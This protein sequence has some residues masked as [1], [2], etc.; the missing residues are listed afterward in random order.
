MIPIKLP[1][2][3]FT[4][5]EK[6]I[7]QFI[8]KQKRPQI[9]KAIL[10]KK[11]GAGGINLP[12]FRLYYKATVIK[13]VWYW[14]KTRTIDQWNKIESPERNPC[15]YEYLI[16][17]K[18]GKNIQKGKDG[19]FNKWCLENWTATCKRMKLEHFLIPYTKI[20]S[21]WIKDLNVKLEAIK[22]LEENIG[23]TI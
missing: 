2:T 3:F 1:M 9:A 23:K 11:N 6:K 13:T 12:D 14:H 10:R 17:N 16:F 18:E 20:N 4:K 7:S 8:W 19:L 15:T 5:L 22:I 21:K